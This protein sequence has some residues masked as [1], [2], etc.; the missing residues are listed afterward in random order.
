LRVATINLN[1]PKNLAALASMPSHKY[2]TIKLVKDRITLLHSLK[3][4]LELCE[5][6][7]F[8]FLS[9]TN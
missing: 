4:E 1:N 6:E 9:A 5:G 2:D 3:K 7:V 8:D